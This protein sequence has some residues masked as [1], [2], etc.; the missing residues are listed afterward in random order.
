MFITLT[1]D[2]SQK[3]KIRMHKKNFNPSTGWR[4][5]I[6]SKKRSLHHRLAAWKRNLKTKSYKLDGQVA[7]F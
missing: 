6:N 2:T 5:S 4:K 7:M 1:I 3:R